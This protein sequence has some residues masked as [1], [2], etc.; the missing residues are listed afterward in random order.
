MRSAIVIAPQN[1][2]ELWNVCTRPSKN[3]GLGFT[4]SQTKAEIDRLKRLFVFLPDTH[5]IYSEWE[6]LVTIYEVKG[7]KV[8]DARLV[9]FMKVHD[10]S[11]IL[12][13]NIRDFRRFGDEVIPVH[14]KDIFDTTE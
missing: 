3:N 4:L 9:A 1:L 7:V 8:H 10:L 6:K 5:K 13:F 2:I 11:H 12:S 14:P